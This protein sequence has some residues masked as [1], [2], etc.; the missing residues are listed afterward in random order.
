MLGAMSIKIGALL[1]AALVVAGG[2]AGKEPSIGKKEKKPAGPTTLLLTD[3]AGENDDS[4]FKA[5]FQGI[6]RFYGETWDN[7]RSRGIL[8]NTARCMGGEEYLPV[9]KAACES[10]YWDLILVAGFTFADALGETAPLYPAQKFAIIDVDWVNEPNVAQYIFAEHEGSY[11]AGAAAALKAAESGAEK[12]VFGFIGGMAS[13]TITKFEMGYVQGVRS[14][15]P[16]AE[17]VDFYADSW[18]DP[19][20]AFRKAGEW[21]DSGVFAVF[22]AAGATGS[23]AIEQARAYRRRGRDVWAVGVDSDQYDV[24][25]YAPNSSAVLTSMIKRV[26]TASFAAITAVR[27]NAFRGSSAETLTL[28]DEGVGFTADMLSGA[29][30]DRMR[31]IREGIVSKRIPVA[32]TYGEALAAGL[33]PPGLQAAD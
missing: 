17:I 7:Q 4:F 13:S 16:E 9:M 26:D 5:T 19:E 10:R 28:E 8:Y 14:I 11:L 20:S 24:G 32:A 23:G 31:E 15:I 6:L 21:F 30:L 27:N 3:V 29:V 12:P 2:C 18:D 25:L 1:M 33:A 22:S